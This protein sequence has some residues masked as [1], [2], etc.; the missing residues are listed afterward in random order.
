MLGV[1]DIAVVTYGVAV[2]GATFG[3]CI[4]ALRALDVD[5]NLGT[6]ADRR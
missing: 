3:Q 6:V 2:R 5:W 1:T 4:Y